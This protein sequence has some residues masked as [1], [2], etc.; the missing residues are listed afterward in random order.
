MLFHVC[1]VLLLFAVVHLYVGTRTRPLYGTY[2]HTHTHRRD[3][4]FIL[5]FFFYLFTHLFYFKNMNHTRS[6]TKHTAE[7]EFEMKTRPWQA[8]V[9][10]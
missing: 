3:S 2:T 5:L 6:H 1:V 8:G 4:Q 9:T 10:E 7:L